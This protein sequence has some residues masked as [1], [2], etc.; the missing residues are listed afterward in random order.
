MKIYCIRHGKSTHN[1][2]YDKI[3]RAAFAGDKP[4]N[5]H[6]VADGVRQATRLYENWKERKEIELIIV[7]PLQR[8][9]ETCECVFGK[10]NSVPVI[11]MD[12]LL[13]FPQGSHT[14]NYRESKSELQN[15]Y[16]SYKFEINE[17]SYVYK[18]EETKKQLQDRV[19]ILKK[20]LLNRNEINI[21]LVG[22]NSFLKE[23]LQE[24]ETIKHCLPILKMLN[25]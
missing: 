14:P 12:T 13:E 9:L 15:M 11:V 7:S 4:F 18:L 20:W 8:T 16:S 17:K 24:E 21:A 6:L 10:Y 25:K 19:E 2:E 23:F 1:V 3:G 5:S 22:H